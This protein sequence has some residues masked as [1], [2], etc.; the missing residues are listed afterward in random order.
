MATKRQKVRATRKDLTFQMADTDE[1]RAVWDGAHKVIGFDPAND[2]KVLKWL[3]D[4]LRKNLNKMS[5]RDE[6]IYGE[7]LRQLSGEYQT[8]GYSSYIVGEELAEYQRTISE[9]IAALFDDKRR[10]WTIPPPK[11]VTLFRKS[12]IVSRGA[13]FQFNL[14]GAERSGILYGVMQLLQN[15]PNRLRACRFCQKP[16]LKTKRQEYCS[17]ECSRAQREKNR[18]QKREQTRLLGWLTK[19]NMISQL[20]GGDQTEKQKLAKDLREQLTATK[21]MDEFWKH[22]SNGTEVVL[23]QWLAM[24]GRKPKDFR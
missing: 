17:A 16:I 11:E 14:R 4:F 7:C 12:P 19:L 13:R 18:H 6:R 2:P 10:S 8:E 5:E 9:G 3:F 1:Y 21:N 20:P 23:K 22:V 15:L 24:K